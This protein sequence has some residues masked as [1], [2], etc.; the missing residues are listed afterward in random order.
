MTKRMTNAGLWDAMDAMTKERDAAIELAD[1]HI[2]RGSELEAQIAN[3]E[4][5]YR[6]Q[7]KF[8]RTELNQS[9]NDH[10]DLI[11][12]AKEA[13]RLI[14]SINSKSVNSFRYDTSD[15]AYYYDN[16]PF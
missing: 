5:V 4:E 1:K 12:D 9:R 14:T 6:S 11:A 10:S 16:P 15:D 7:M 13:I 3:G 2:K 8:V